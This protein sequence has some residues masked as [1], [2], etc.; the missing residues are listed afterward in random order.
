VQTSTRH[1]FIPRWPRPLN[2]AAAVQAWGPAIGFGVKSTGSAPKNKTTLQLREAIANGSWNPALAG[3]TLTLSDPSPHQR[4]RFDRPAGSSTTNPT[5]PAGKASWFSPRRVDA[6]PAAL[7]ATTGGRP[8]SAWHQRRQPCWLRAPARPAAC[9]NHPRDG[10]RRADPQ[11]TGGWRDPA[12]TQVSAP[13]EVRL[14]APAATKTAKE[15]LQRRNGNTNGLPGTGYLTP[16][17]GISAAPGRAMTLS[18][19]LSQAQ[20]A[21]QGRAR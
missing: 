18:G 20:P 14:S 17:S 16:A 6:K 8:A 9:A 1:A 15:N 11:W 5:G 10:Q 12:I 19:R 7:S 4:C 2:G 21:A 13:L 3:G